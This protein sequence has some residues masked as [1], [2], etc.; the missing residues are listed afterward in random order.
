MTLPTNIDPSDRITINAYLKH[1]YIDHKPP[2]PSE[3]PQQA[4]TVAMILHLAELDDDA[5]EPNVNCPSLWAEFPFRS[6]KKDDGQ[7]PNLCLAADTLYAVCRNLRAQHLTGGATRNQAEVE[8]SESNAIAN[9]FAHMAFLSKWLADGIEGNKFPVAEEYFYIREPWM[10]HGLEI[11][12]QG[13]TRSGKPKREN[14][15]LP[16]S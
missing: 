6:V 13:Q 12:C 16:E 5:G 11:C 10:F 1:T 14:M 8:V 4:F 2:I 15:A 7:D 3:R 9:D